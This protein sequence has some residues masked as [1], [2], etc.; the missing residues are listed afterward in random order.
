MA[1]DSGLVNKHPITSKFRS[2][3]WSPGLRSEPMNL[4]LLP[5][6]YTE[7]PASRSGSSHHG[8]CHLPAKGPCALSD[9]R[10][11]QSWQGQFAL[12]GM[13]AEPSLDMFK[14][15]EADEILG[16]RWRISQVWMKPILKFGGIIGSS[17]L[18]K[19]KIIRP[20]R[21]NAVFKGRHWKQWVHNKIQA[22]SA[23]LISSYQRNHKLFSKEKNTAKRW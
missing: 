23:D 15:K 10:A 19:I 16:L 12:Q 21:P 9:V 6:W 8:L 5:W 17:D 7:R 2:Y 13:C 14:Q 20:S 1:G 3:I 4:Q 22:D 11:V 18:P